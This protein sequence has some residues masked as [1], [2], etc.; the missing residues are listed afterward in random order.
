MSEIMCLWYRV[1]LL[2]GGEGDAGVGVG[3]VVV[4]DIILLS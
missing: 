2:L 4:V 3:G 1:M